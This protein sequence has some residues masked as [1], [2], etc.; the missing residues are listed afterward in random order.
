M[1]KGNLKGYQ[2][3]SFTAAKN[4]MQNYMD[5]V[6]I[7]NAFMKQYKLQRLSYREVDWYIWTTRKYGLQNLLTTLI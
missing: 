7:Y 6:A 1:I 5:Y 4:V 2:A 3:S